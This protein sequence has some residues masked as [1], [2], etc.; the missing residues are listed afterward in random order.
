MLRSQELVWDGEQRNL[1]VPDGSLL[2]ALG[3]RLGQVKWLEAESALELFSDAHAHH[4]E[5]EDHTVELHVR[6]SIAD[7]SNLW[8]PHLTPASNNVIGDAVFRSPAILLSSQT[9]AIAFIPNLDDVRAIREDDGITG[10]RA[11]LDY[12]HPQSTITLAIG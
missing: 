8:I 10:A 11:W 3:P 1:V 5:D 2:R 6:H 12:N 9:I 4:N 7:L